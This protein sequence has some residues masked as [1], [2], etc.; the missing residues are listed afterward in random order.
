MT[1]F[2]LLASWVAMAAAAM[3]LTACGGSSMFPSPSVAPPAASAPTIRPEEIVG[4]WG[5][6]AYYNEKDRARTQ[7]A[8]AAECTRPV[9]ITRGP[10]GGVMMPVVNQA[11]AE[12]TIKGGPGGKNFL[13]PPGEAGGDK[14]SEIISFDGRILVTRTVASDEVGHATSVYVRCGPKA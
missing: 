1:C 10:N 13:G 4:K 9:V 5:Y 2:R 6:G 7:T 14:D 3:M 8:A 11:Q 12:L